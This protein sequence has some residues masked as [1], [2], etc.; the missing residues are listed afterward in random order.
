MLQRHPVDKTTS[1]QPSPSAACE[2]TVAAS[3][4]R[5]AAHAAEIRAKRNDPAFKALL[6]SEERPMS[7]FPDVLRKLE[8]SPV[9]A[10]DSSSTATPSSL[11]PSSRLFP[12]DSGFTTPPASLNLIHAPSP[13]FSIHD[14]G[15]VAADDSPLGPQVRDPVDIAL[16]HLLEMGFEEA[17]ATKALADADTGNCVDFEKAV[18]ILVRQRKRDVSNLTNRNYRGPIAPQIPRE[19]ERRVSPKP[20][21][22]L[23]IGGADRYA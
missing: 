22:G 7:T 1:A 15:S 3:R 11:A 5:V 4:Q 8:H 19:P 21:V 17:K 18:E 10:D 14:G 13:C 2:G 12:S 9:M 16:E 20:R 6:P 23:G